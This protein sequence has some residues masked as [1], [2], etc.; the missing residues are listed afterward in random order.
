MDR[1]EICKA[2]IDTFD[3]Q[4][5]LISAFD[6]VHMNKI[7]FEGSWTAAQVV[8]HT[9]LAN[10]G[11]VQVLHAEVRDT[12]RPADL[13][14]PRIAADFLNFNTKMESPESIVPEDGLYEPAVLLDQVKKVYSDVTNVI[15]NLDLT[16]T[17][18]SFELPGYG[19]L[20]RMEA[21]YFIV[22]HT[23][24]HNHQLRN[25]KQLVSDGAKVN[26]FGWLVYE[27]LSHS[28]DRLQANQTPIFW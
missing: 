22:C 25:I 26:I 12:N 17:C 16:K 13:I 4:E 21:V 9:L 1:I 2:C 23:K 28:G 10:A 27:F 18:A 24:R 6:A 20:T 7:P 14:V 15:E 5:S 3:E 11:F 19:Y 8:Q